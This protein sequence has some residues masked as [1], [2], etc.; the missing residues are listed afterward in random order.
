MDVVLVIKMVILLDDLCII[1]SFIRYFSEERSSILRLCLCRPMLTSTLAYLTFLSFALPSLALPHFT[2]LKMRY[3]TSPQLA[4]FY[5][6]L[7]FFTSYRILP[8]LTSRYLS[9]MLQRMLVTFKPIR[10]FSAAYQIEAAACFLN[11]S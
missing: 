7:L 3:L 4:L 1:T 5:R 2:Y 6:G 11:I 8:Y 10:I 9:H